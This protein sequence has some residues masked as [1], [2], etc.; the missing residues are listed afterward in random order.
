MKFKSMI[1]VPALT[2][3]IAWTTTVLA[4]PPAQSGIVTRDEAEDFGIIVDQEAG[5]ILITGIDPVEFCAGNTDSDGLPNIIVDIPSDP[6]RL[7]RFV[8]GEGQTSVWDFVQFNCD[9]FNALQPVA[10]GMAVTNYT[11]NDFNLAPTPNA[12][13]F[14]FT[15]NGT[16]YDPITSEPKH[17][18]AVWQGLINKQQGIFSSKLQR[19]KLK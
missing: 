14:G 1:L 17:L 13:A 2:A 5:L 16:L 11:D 10:V 7:A 3:V 12:N 19:I 8:R 4:G 9:M 15:V 18:N 6:E